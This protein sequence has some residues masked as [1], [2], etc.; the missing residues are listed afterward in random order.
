MNPRLFDQIYRFLTRRHRAVKAAVKALAGAGAHLYSRLTGFMLP[1][2]I[3]TA[4]TMLLCTYEAS[5]VAL[6]RRLLRP[7][8]TVVD[9][10]AHVGYY[11]RLF[12]RLVGATGA[13]YAFEPHPRNFSL[14]EHNTKRLTNV[15][16]ISLAL[17][18][19]EGETR[20]FESAQATGGHSL[21]ASRGPYTREI[22]VRT[23]SLDEWVGERDIDLIKLDVEGA[24]LEVLRGARKMI[25]RAR[26]LALIV[27]FYPRAQ[28]A[29]GMDPRTLLDELRALGF[30]LAL[31][32][33]GLGRLI[34]LERWP[35]AEAFVRSVPKYVNLLGTKGSAR[36][37]S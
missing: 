11:T 34:P 31:I 21:L 4:Y 1:P 19:R 30:D 14:L 35:T 24:E 16:R 33:E 10:G 2:D 29:R 8:M 27:E 28:A 13:V 22:A 9:V 15:V 17:S 7:G 23:T 36:A 6:L 18:D 26:R 37:E 25:G 12:S 3:V 32:E 5:T 20:L